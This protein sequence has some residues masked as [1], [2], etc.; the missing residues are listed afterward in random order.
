MKD[1]LPSPNRRR[2]LGLLA[3]LPFLGG[4]RS[5]TDNPALVLPSAVAESPFADGVTVLVAGPNGGDLRRWADRLLP[6][7]AQSVATETIFQSPAVGAADGVTGANQFE[8]RAVPDGHTL[9]LAP[10]EAALAWLIGDP[11]AKFD[12]G[13]WVPIMAGLIPAVVVGKAGGLTPGRPIHIAAGRTGWVDLPAVLAA[14]LLGAQPVP[15]TDIL[16]ENALQAAFGRGA[17]DAFLLRGHDVPAQVNAFAQLGAR[18]WFTLGFID[19]AGRPARD[20][21]FPDL[22]T[23]TELHETV[24]G[25]CPSGPLFEAWTAAAAASQLEFGLVLPQ[26]TPASMVALWRRAG[27]GTASAPD[28]Q[29]LAWSLALRPLGGTAATAAMGALS[30]SQPALLA[31]RGWLAGRFNWRPA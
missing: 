31:L 20:P 11:R 3:S 2:W 21:R 1:A 26:L 5:A 12:V 4:G 7:L 6:A 25:I 17:V 27:T 8:T 22:P 14:E 13:H 9:L 29:A 19:E 18:P 23:F 28:V 10:G 15:M 30:A 24:R 16:E